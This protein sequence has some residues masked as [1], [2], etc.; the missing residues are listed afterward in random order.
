VED[1]EQVVG[2]LASGVAADDE[3]SRPQAL[4]DVV[5]AL[6][7]E[8]VAG[9]GFGEGKFGGRGLEVLAEEDGVVAVA[10]GV[11]ADADAARQLRSSNLVW[12]QRALGTR[13]ED[14]QG[15]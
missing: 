5:Q 13:S 7:D 4:A 3:G 8:G 1:V 14:K 12:Y 6:S 10:R 2:V 9:G 11:D 15:P